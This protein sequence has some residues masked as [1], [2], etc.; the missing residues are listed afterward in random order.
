MIFLTL[1]AVDCKLGLWSEESCT[2]TCG[3]SVTK[4]LTRKIVQQ[5]LYRGKPCQDKTEK[6]EICNVSPCPGDIYF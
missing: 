5:P 1:F 3:T 6:T 2:A 4:R